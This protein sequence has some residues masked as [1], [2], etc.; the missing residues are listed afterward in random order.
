MS[1]LIPQDVDA[2]DGPMK[3]QIAADE[4]D[5]LTRRPP[6]DSPMKADEDEA[7]G[8][9]PIRQRPLDDVDEASMESFPCSDPPAYTS[10]H[11]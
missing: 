3:R 1:L 2:N 10:C 7:T 9:P 5:R 4:E 8:I 11:A 6:G